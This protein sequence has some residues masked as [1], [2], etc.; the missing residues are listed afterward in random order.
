MTPR[1][2]W[3]SAVL[4]LSVAPLNTS[5]ATPARFD[6]GT[7]PAAPDY[8]QVTPETLFSKERGFGFEPG[9]VLTAVNRGGKD[10]LCGDF[11][12]SEAPFHFTARVPT[13]GNYR[14]TV[15]LGDS[16]D[17][18]VTTIRAELRR[19]M[20]EKV[21]TKAGEFRRVSFIVNT[22]TPAIAGVGPIKMGEVRLKAPRETVQEAWAWDDAITLEFANTRPAVCAMEI[23]PVE[24]P[25]IFLLGDS[26]VCDQSKEPYNSWGQM[27]TR[28][29]TPEVTIANHGESGETYRARFAR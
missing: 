11:V 3:V 1:H 15:M 25:T 22:R 24:V 13:E 6:F 19:L 21:E 17:V 26:T 7:G 20:V 4:A 14:V 28:W 29:F 18:T 16:A 27:L 2:L 10:P 12:T 23:E 5:A 8:T 9:R